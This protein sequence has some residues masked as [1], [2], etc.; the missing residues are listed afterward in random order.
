MESSP[1]NSDSERMFLTRPRVLRSNHALISA[2]A[3]LGFSQAHRSRLGLVDSGGRVGEGGAEAQ[4]GVG[5]NGGGRPDLGLQVVPAAG[6]DD[7][8]DP[9]C[10]WPRGAAPT[11][12]RKV[13]I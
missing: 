11:G 8:R 3:S 2:A 7:G 4:R 12:P 9:R 6:E 10:T 5:P 1:S 13:T